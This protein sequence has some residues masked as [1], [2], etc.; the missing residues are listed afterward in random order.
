M[1][2]TLPTPSFAR[3]AFRRMTECAILLEVERQLIASGDLHPGQMEAAKVV[4]IERARNA[5]AEIRPWMRRR[6]EALRQKA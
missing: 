5:T 4:H 2:A 6:D 1:N 3:I